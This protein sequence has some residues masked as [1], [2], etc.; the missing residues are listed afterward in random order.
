MR[1]RKAKDRRGAVAVEFAFIAP[2]FVAMFVGLTQVTYLMQVQ[3]QFAMAARE[4]ARTASF[5]RSSSEGGPSTN[6]KM[7]EDI[8]NFL[9]ANGLPGDD[10]DVIIADADDELVEFDLDDPDN[11]YEYFQVIVE[12][13]AADLFQTAPPG[14]DEFKISARVIFRNGAVD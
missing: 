12:H 4:G 13:S 1:L 11:E 5:E 9:N 8:R 2:L 7:I 3:N 10:V 14:S 6:D